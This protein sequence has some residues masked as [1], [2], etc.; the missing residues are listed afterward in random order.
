M[1]AA[2]WI[3]TGTPY[4]WAALLGALLLSLLPL[5]SALALITGGTGNEPID[6]PG[7]PAG[8]ETV[9]NH[10]GRVAWWEGPSISVLVSEVASLASG[11]G[12]QLPIKF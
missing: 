8:A 1:I 6:D 2:R 12:N 5:Q 11:F 10:E 4:T 3:G 9:F 7:W